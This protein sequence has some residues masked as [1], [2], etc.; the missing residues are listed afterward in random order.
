MG[1]RLIKRH[2]EQPLWIKPKSISASSSVDELKNDIYLRNEL[3]A[4]LELK[5]TTSSGSSPKYPTRYRAR[6]AR[7]RSSIA[8]LG[9]IKK[10]LKDGVKSRLLAR[11][12]EEL[13]LLPELLELLEKS[14][15]DDPPLSVK[16]GGMIKP[17]YDGEVDKLRAARQNGQN[18]LSDLERK[19]REET[20]I[21]N[22]KISFNKVFGYYIE[23]TRSNLNLVPTYR[24]V[25]KQTLAG[26]ERYITPEL[27]DLEEL[28]LSSEY[29]CAKREYQI[30]E[31]IRSRIEEEIEAL[32]K[33]ADLLALVDVLQS[34]AQ[35]AYDYDFVKP[36]MA[37]DGEIDIKGGRHPVVERAVSQEFVPNDV[38]M[39]EGEN[40]LLIITGPN[41][42]GKSTFMR[43][44]ALIVL[45][46][47]MG[48]FVPAVS[49]K[50]S[51]TD[52]IF[53]RVG[54]SDD[55][56]SGQSTF[57]VEMNELASILNNATSKSLLVLDEIG[58]GTSTIDGLSIAW[59]TI[60]YILD[61]EHGLKCKTL[62]ATHY[63]ELIGL[64]NVL[65]GVKNYSV[66]V[67][68]FN[69]TV[70]FLHK[71]KKGGADKSFGVEVA[72]LAGLPEKLT[73]RA[74]ALVAVLE[75]NG[76]KDIAE[77]NRENLLSEA[78]REEPVNKNAEKLVSALKNL[79]INL[80]TPLE[81][82][83]ILNELKQKI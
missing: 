25:R 69:R 30:F 43:Q 22:L 50:I 63:H 80:L 75:E 11:A 60:E 23:V 44:T 74:K 42:A 21:K 15:A 10:T 38:F 1:G 61:A 67:K 64:E 19:E 47:Q 82:L 9:K 70:I 40:K 54:A 78:P 16:E 72:K 79:D 39:D 17:G 31:S 73:E 2:I 59:A 13:S 7:L 83:S 48:S 65:P 46:A 26:S 55:L 49:A 45:M 34:F 32:Q 62:F 56:S 14:I 36:Q 52:R 37:E 27:K 53:T 57:M 5:F 8:S 6:R 81:A 29:K 20:G 12:G 33:N 3:R 18:W 58:R 24:Y 28:L 41:M 68:E 77:L 4:R 51:V 66:T 71:I 35:A 76:G